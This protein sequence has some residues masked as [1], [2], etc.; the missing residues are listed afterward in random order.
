MKTSATSATIVTFLP[1]VLLALLLWKF[2]A[3]PWPSLKIAGFVVMLLSG[4]LLTV[5]RLQLGS[6]FSVT[7]Q[8]T[9]LVTHGL[10]AKIR[11]PVYVFSAIL[12]VGLAL[13]LNRLPLLWFLVVLIPMQILRARKESEILGA[14]FGDSYRQYKSTTWF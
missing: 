11:N 9:A 10:Y 14:H 5:A 12:L 1:I 4:T 8:A 13:Y 3:E 7:P 6:S 2:A